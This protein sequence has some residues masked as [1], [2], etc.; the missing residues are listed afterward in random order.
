VVG[1]NAEPEARVEMRQTET[2]LIGSVAYFPERYGEA[3]VR[4][5]TDIL[6]GKN[7]SPAA[8]TRHQVVTPENVNRI[9]PNDM[10]FGALAREYA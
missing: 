10:L 6:S 8:F 5:A 1:Q 4:I 9:Y 3:I 7:V 2:R